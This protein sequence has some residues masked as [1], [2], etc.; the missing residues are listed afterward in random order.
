MEWRTQRPAK[1]PGMIEPCIPTRATKP[2]V[3][4][5]WIHEIKHDGYR[6][7]ARKRDSRVR[8]FTRNGF[9]WTE[10][11]PRIS[12]SVAALRA[13]QAV[14]D[15]EAVW[16]DGDGL[17]IFDKLHS[18]A[19]DGEV[20]LYAFDLLELHG[21]DWRPRP[22]E[23]RKARLAKLLANAPA[24]VHYTEHL[25]GDGAAIFPRL[26][27]RGRGHCVEAPRAAVES[28]AQDQESAGAWYVAFQGGAMTKRPGDLSV[29]RSPPLAP[30]ARD[31][32][33]PEPK[34]EMRSAA[35][36][37]RRRVGR[38]LRP[39]FWGLVFAALAAFG[40]AAIISVIVHLMSAV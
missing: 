31:G 6:L 25:E 3:G 26:Q 2:P 10:R 23:E 39:N 8:L 20:I 21:E 13:L 15:G 4:P 35:E 28:L 17:A 9:D 11:Y 12:E 16:C 40:I 34:S 38:A 22:L 5:Q 18:R 36:I 29:T 7:I 19:Y 30:G 37:D 14:I 1:R 32:G 33:G 24:G 27:A